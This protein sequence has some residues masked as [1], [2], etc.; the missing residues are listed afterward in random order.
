MRIRLFTRLLGLAMIAGLIAMAGLSLASVDRIRIGG[1][2]YGGI[3]DA[4]DFTA[5]ILPPPLYLVEAYAVALEA[6]EVPSEAPTAA[7]K[8]RE[9]KE[10]YQARIDYW[11]ARE[12]DGDLKGLL[13]GPGEAASAR[14]WTVAIDELMPAAERGDAQAVLASRQALTEAYHAQRAVVDQMV[15]KAAALALTSESDA[16]RKMTV[17]LWAL[18]ILIALV[19][20]LA[21]VSMVLMSRRLVRPLVQ[22]TVHMRELAAGDLSRDAPHAGR[23]DEIG[24]MGKAVQIF[25]RN[26]LALREAADRQSAM[27]AAGQAERER[28]ETERRR[29]AEEQ[30]LV[31]ETL[32][33]ALSRLAAADITARVQGLPPA[34][35]QL[36]D[37]YNRALEVL[38]QSLMAV[39]SAS[40][41]FSSGASHLA[42]AA[43]ELSH[44]TEQQAAS[45]EE[46]AA[47]LEQATINAGQTASGAS[48]AAR[49]V[50]S[51]RQEA[52]ESGQVVRQAVSAMEALTASSR[53]MAQIIS[54]IDEIAFQTNL[55]AL[56]AGVEAARAGESG[57]GFAVVA[58]EVRALAQRSAEAAKEI[59][60]L[61]GTSN[62]Q[63]GQG[64]DM[65]DR[66]GKALL[67][68]AGQVGEIDSVVAAI[69]AAAR[70]QAIGL[71]EVTAAVSQ[72]DQITQKNA[73]MVEETSAACQTLQED[74]GRLIG[75]VRRFRLDEE[76]R[77]AA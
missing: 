6:S 25:R 66:A 72:M 8:L 75:T 46:S 10:Q 1:G 11:R 64:F 22:T 47:A 19:G 18:G 50:S 35:R 65:V 4:K 74:A 2:A 53:Q 70:E 21:V 7:K 45:L 43:D 58:Q 59:K 77:L 49:L 57:R 32:A 20:A 52:E 26:A 38:Q 15:P 40:Q 29:T 71:G 33:Q 9:L 42:R 12:F 48:D 76:R 37:D 68:I 13:L 67:R 31:V 3:I 14:F 36:Q 55:L 69:A 39:A 16:T 5:D 63:V 30:R 44:R 23:T 24:D 17:A 61:I 28:A 41:T 62:N 34:Y 27:E 60:D 51:T 56:N 73:A 54:A